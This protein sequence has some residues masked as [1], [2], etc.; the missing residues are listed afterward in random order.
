MQ[1]LQFA[2]G[3]VPGLRSPASASASGADRE[4]MFDVI[5]TGCGPTGAKLATLDPIEGI[6]DK[7]AGRDY[8]EVMR[9]NLSALR[10]GQRCR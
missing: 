5:I 9:S 8:F 1:P 3:D 4:P 2:V 6:N 10:Q 7:S